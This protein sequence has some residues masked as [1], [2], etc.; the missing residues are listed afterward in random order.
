MQQACILIA[1]L[2]VSK[3]VGKQL[4]KKQ[5]STRIQQLFHNSMRIILEPLIEVGKKGMEV[6]GGDGKVRMVHP[7]LAH[8]ENIILLFL[9]IFANI[10]LYMQ[11]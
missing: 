9:A 2:S 4:T 1:Y 10:A 11:I 7:I 8:Q 6:T 5:K 3:T